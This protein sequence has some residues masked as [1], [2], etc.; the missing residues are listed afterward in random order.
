MDNLRYWNEYVVGTMHVGS[1]G[2]RVFF[3]SSLS[4]TGPLG[5]SGGLMFGVQLYPRPDWVVGGA[6]SPGSRDL[7]GCRAVRI[8]DAPCQQHGG[9]GAVNADHPGHWTTRCVKLLGS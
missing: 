9:W 5:G 2:E 7:R 4:F 8:D 1:L 6:G 3:Y